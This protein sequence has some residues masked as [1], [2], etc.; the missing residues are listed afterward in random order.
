MSIIYHV[1]AIYNREYRTYAAKGAFG[2]GVTAQYWVQQNGAAQHH[3]VR[4]YEY[5]LSLSLSASLSL[6]PFISPSLVFFPVLVSFQSLCHNNNNMFPF[7]LS[8]TLGW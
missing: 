3:Q 6:S 8:F 7:S 4:D 1:N 5:L 2:I